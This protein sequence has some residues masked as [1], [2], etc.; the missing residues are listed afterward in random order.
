MLLS[1]IGRVI[2]F[3]G[4]P[5]D[6]SIC[7]IGASHRPRIAIC[8]VDL[9]RGSKLGLVR[10]SRCTRLGTKVQK[11]RGVMIACGVNDR[12]D[13]WSF[14]NS[15]LKGSW[16]VAVPRVNHRRRGKSVAMME[17]RLHQR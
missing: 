2:G 10:C 15:E 13:M 9:R 8:R 4:V 16:D 3:T 1:S 5:Y 12:A 11:V 17:H 7:D 6:R 14:R